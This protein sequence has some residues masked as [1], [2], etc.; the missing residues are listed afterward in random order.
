MADRT[1]PHRAPRSA[2]VWSVLRGELAR[3]AAAHAGPAPA[4]VVDVG[5]GTGRFAVPLAE[6]GHRVVVVDPNPDALATLARRA[7]EHGVADRVTAVQGD[8]DALLDL[9]GPGSADLLLCH[10]VLEVVDDPVATMGTLA[11]VLAPG[12]CVSLL[13]AN[14]GGAVL[15]RALS[16]YFD[17]ARALLTDPAGIAGDG[18]AMRRRFDGGSLTRLVEG[19]GLVVEQVHGVG[20]VTDLV[21]G[22]AA[23]AEPGAADALIELEAA[24]AG[25]PPYRDIATTLHLLA[26]RT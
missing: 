26:R 10:S 15:S 24:L 9:V 17:V 13:T 5:G 6:A 19:V 23:T 25:R 11:T 14:R 18:D 21:S 22:T 1:G 16:G 8:A 20:V 12:G 7:T 4:A 2:V 3:R